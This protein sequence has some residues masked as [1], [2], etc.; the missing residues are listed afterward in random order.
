LSD[1]E[2][3]L[4]EWNAV[5][6]KG[7]PQLPDGSWRPDAVQALMKLSAQLLTVDVDQAR[8]LGV[9]PIGIPPDLEKRYPL[10]K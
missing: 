2:Q 7:D 1:A 5:C 8:A 10:P 6:A 3:A 9:R 4:A